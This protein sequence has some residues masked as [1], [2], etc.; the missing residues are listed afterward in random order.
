MKYLYLAGPIEQCNYVEIHD[1]RNYVKTKLNPNITTIYPKV[2]QSSNSKGILNQNKTD[3][4]NCDIVLSYIPK[5]IE[6]RRP[7]YG[8]I[9]ELSFAYSVGK[10]TILVSD[11]KYLVKHP[12]IREINDIFPNLEQSIQYINSKFC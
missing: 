10:Y 6:R 1:W 5:S 11:D 8:T 7:S 4:L 3:V 9:F 12:I 2:L